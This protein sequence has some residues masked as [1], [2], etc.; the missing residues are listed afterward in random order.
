MTHYKQLN[1]NEQTHQKIKTLA[2]IKKQKYATTK[3]PF[4]WGDAFC[5]ATAIEYDA[6]FIITDDTEFKKVKEIPI[7]FI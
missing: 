5:L 4:A 6:D 2:S 7:I 1:V 3:E